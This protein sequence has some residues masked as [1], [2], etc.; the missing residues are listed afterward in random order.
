M[1]KTHALTHPL[2]MSLLLQLCGEATGKGPAWACKSTHGVSVDTPTTTNQSAPPPHSTTAYTQGLQRATDATKTVRNRTQRTGLMAV[3]VP[4]PSLLEACLATTLCHE[5]A[6]H[7]AI[8]QPATLCPP[9]LIH[10]GCT[11][12]PALLTVAWAACL[13][14]LLL[15]PPLRC[16]P[17][18]EHAA[19]QHPGAWTQHAAL[20]GASLHSRVSFRG[21]RSLVRRPPSPHAASPGRPCAALLLDLLAQPP[22]RVGAALLPHPLRELLGPA[23]HCQGS[24]LGC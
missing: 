12:M 10:G 9:A 16:A 1:Y 11:C 7:E 3:T 21:G 6:A 19:Q 17:F 20:R 4:Q 18:P 13:H 23:Q 15:A 5:A 22:C 24:V 8:A 14:L 2:W